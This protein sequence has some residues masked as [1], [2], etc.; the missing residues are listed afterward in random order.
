M[1]L[2]P[3]KDGIFAALGAIDS[4]NSKYYTP[5]WEKVR[6]VRE[7]NMI[8][9][10]FDSHPLE[11]GDW[12]C[13]R[14]QQNSMKWRFTFN[15]TDGPVVVEFDPSSQHN[16]CIITSDAAHA[17]AVTADDYNDN[18]PVQYWIL[19]RFPPHPENPNLDS[20]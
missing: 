20:L 10:Y 4:Q 12:I 15:T 1:A 8:T 16:A 13:L 14:G 2:G 3:Q 7:N 19:R 11:T 9:G 18:T 17:Y 5:R 6:T